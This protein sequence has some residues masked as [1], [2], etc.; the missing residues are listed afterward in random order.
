M[1][2]YPNIYAKLLFL[3]S[4][5]TLQNLSQPLHFLTLIAQLVVLCA[6]IALTHLWVDLNNIA[7][8][9]FLYLGSKVHPYG[10][11]KIAFLGLFWKQYFKVLVLPISL[12]YWLLGV[13][14]RS[15]VIL[16]SFSSM[17]FARRQ[18]WRL[19]GSGTIKRFC[20]AK[21]RCGFTC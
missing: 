14:S 21:F 10:T 2:V 11:L 20:G 6:C 13:C 4:N 17:Y 9:V 7:P 18:P 1:W 8:S 16:C 12:W 5:L 19:M 3:H 15:L